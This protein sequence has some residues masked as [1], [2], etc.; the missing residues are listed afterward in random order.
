[1]KSSA[2]ILLAIAAAMLA[3][4]MAGAQ[5]APAAPGMPGYE[6]A[7]PAIPATPLMRPLP[8][9]QWTMLQIRQSFELADSDAN[10]QLTRAEAQQLTIMPRSFEDIDENKDGVISRAEYESVFTR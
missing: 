4:A 9:S 3:A 2:S 5:T 8:P 6:P 10:G 7:V 1:M